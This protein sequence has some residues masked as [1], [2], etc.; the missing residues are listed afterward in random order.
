VVSSQSQVLPRLLTVTKAGMELLQSSGT[1]PTSRLPGL[2]KPL[3]FCKHSAVESFLIW[4]T[5]FM[6]ITGYVL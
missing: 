6:F 1:D 2:Q 4:R 5:C 3:G